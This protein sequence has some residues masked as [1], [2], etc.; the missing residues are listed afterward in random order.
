MY[1]HGILA[2]LLEVPMLVPKRAQLSLSYFLTLLL[3][4]NLLLSSHDRIMTKHNE[5]HFSS[6]FLVQYNSFHMYDRKS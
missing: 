1:F 4:L 5:L 3:P 2:F 6:F